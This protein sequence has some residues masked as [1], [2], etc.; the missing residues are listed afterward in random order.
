LRLCLL[1]SLHLR[2]RTD[3]NLFETICQIRGDE[4]DGAGTHELV[5]HIRGAG[6]HELVYHI[7]GE[8]TPAQQALGP[9]TRR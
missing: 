4:L 5:H 9:T 1:P 7:R 6:T 8:A 2:T 3:A